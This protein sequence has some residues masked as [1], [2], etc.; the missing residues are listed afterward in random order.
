MLFATSTPELLA[1]YDDQ[2]RGAE[3]SYLPPGVHLEPDGPIVRVMGHQRGF[4]SAPPDLELN[5]SSVDALIARQRDFFAARGEAVEW[6]T[7]GHD[8]PADLPDRLVAAGF[9]PE[10]AETVVVAA[11]RDLAR[12]DPPRP[13]GAPTFNEGFLF[14]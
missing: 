3:R 8:Q 5:G 14:D 10:P 7:R 13:D 11:T 6:K 4:V 2:L 12:A 9:V 1:A